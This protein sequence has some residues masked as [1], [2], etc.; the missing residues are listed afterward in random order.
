METELFFTDE[1]VLSVFAGDSRN[2][3]VIISAATLQSLS[4]NTNPDSKIIAGTGDA[5]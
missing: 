4:R 2:R 5:V 1:S 3:I